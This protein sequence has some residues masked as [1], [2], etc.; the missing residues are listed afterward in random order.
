ML[1]QSYFHVR[2]AVW[3]KCGIH[4]SNATE[5]CVFLFF[6]AAYIHRR[7]PALSCLLD[8][9]SGLS[10][11]ATRQGILNNADQTR[12]GHRR[13]YL[14][15]VILLLGA[16]DLI[17]FIQIF[18]TTTWSGVQ[19]TQ[20]NRL[21]N[22]YFYLPLLC[23]CI[24]YRSINHHFIEEDNTLCHAAQ[25]RTD[26]N[27]IGLVS[28]NRI[29]PQIASISL[30]CL[31]RRDKG[32]DVERKEKGWSEWVSKDCRGSKSVFPEG[33]VICKGL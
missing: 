33:K 19:G 14:Y 12:V 31:R 18:L 24:T 28:K 4:I 1:R 29:N 30:R 22:P 9:Q 13:S 6:S 27:Y 2:H 26:W 15:L 23:T 7:G 32:G 11:K 17:Q 16:T 21:L 3:Y 25:D 10:I 20:E 5:M 8:G